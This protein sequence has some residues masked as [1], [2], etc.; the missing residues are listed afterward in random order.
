MKQRS[1]KIRFTNKSSTNLVFR[2]EPWGDEVTLNPESFVTIDAY[3]PE[4]G[5]PEVE[6][7]HEQ[8]TYYGWVGS[9]CDFVPE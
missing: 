8:I 1:F 4:N 5:Y 2:L 6:V 3:G 9:V 7:S